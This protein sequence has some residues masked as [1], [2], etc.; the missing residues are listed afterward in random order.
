MRLFDYFK[1][2]QNLLIFK[3]TYYKF[4]WTCYDYV[5]KFANFT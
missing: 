2:A 4:P 3:L 5:I 1:H